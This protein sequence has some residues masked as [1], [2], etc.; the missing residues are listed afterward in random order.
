MRQLRNIEITQT[1]MKHKGTKKRYL[2]SLATIVLACATMTAQEDTPNA[3]LMPGEAPQPTKYVEVKEEKQ[4]LVFFQGFTLSGD[5]YGPAAYSLSD[6]GWVE[7]ALRLN[8]KNTYFPIVEAGYG[9]CEKSEFNTSIT[10]KAK[11]PYARVGL[12]FNLLKNKFQDNR[13]YAGFRYGLSK[14][15]YDM[16]GPAIDDPIWGGSEPFSISDIDC[17]S[18]WGE[19]VFGVEVKMYKNFHMGWLL[20]YKRELSS[21]K[22]DNAKPACIPGYGYTTNA[23]CWSGSFNLIFDLNWGKKKNKPKSIS[24]SIKDIEKGND[25]K[26]VD[27][28]DTKVEHDDAKDEHDANGRMSDSEDGKTFDSEEIKEDKPTVKSAN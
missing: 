14:F 4:Q 8:L 21:T 15:K 19:V 22:S 25:T 10:Y 11:A 20:R 3:A 24:I 5:V 23:S 13:L 9:S 6:Y 2:I 26:H 18:Q 27:H 17:T 7:G 1:D 16:S 28:N 12:D